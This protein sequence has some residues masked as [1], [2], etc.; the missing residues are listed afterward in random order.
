MQEKNSVL[1]EQQGQAKILMIMILVPIALV[2][3]LVM[4]TMTSPVLDLLWPQID[5]MSA[6][7]YISI[8]GSLKMFISLIPTVII[9]LYLYSIVSETTQG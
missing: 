4:L 7:G 3:F 6:D 2:L 1:S 8:A 9:L 5:S